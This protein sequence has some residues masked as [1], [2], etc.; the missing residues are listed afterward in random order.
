[1]QL[2]KALA[3]AK[4]LEQEETEDLRTVTTETTIETRGIGRMILADLRLGAGKA[5]HQ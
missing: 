5:N 4:V 3:G 2:G 1:M